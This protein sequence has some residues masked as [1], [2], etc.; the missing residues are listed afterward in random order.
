M[1]LAEISDYIRERERA[2]VADI[3]NRFDSDP[4]VVRKML[5]VLERKQRIHKVPSITACGSSCRQCDPAA[6][7]LYAWGPSTGKPEEQAACWP[8]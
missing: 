4:E 1:I 8:V 7:E 2:S 5:S 3:A 6:T